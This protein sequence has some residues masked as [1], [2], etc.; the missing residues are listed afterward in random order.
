[1]K[2]SN[3]KL[4][5]QKI[6]DF[7]LTRA[8]PFLIII[9]F[10]CNTLISQNLQ[11]SFGNQKEVNIIREENIS[12]NG[13]LGMALE[14]SEDGR[15]KMLPEWNNGELFKIFNTE[16]RLKNKST[17]WYGEHAGKWLY[18]TAKAVARTGDPVLKELLL[19]EANYL[20]DN[21]EADGYMGTYSPEQR[22]TN[23]E[24]THN[25]SWDIWNL[26][27]ML[28][29]L[30]EVNKHF[31]DPKYENAA[32]KIGELFL[33]VFGDGQNNITD[34]GTR[35][36]ISASIILDP[37]IELYNLT[38]DGRYLNF[39]KLIIKEVE[40]KEGLQIISA[41][42]Q[43]KDMVYIGEGK[44]Y[45]LIWNLTALAKFYKI[46]GE[47]KYIEAV[48]NAWNN[49]VN[50][51]LSICGGPWG[52]IG[53][54]YEL[55]NRA[56]FWNPYGYIETCSSMAW[57]Q[58]N[59]EL[60]ELSGQAKYIK[61]IEKTTFNALIGAQYPNGIDWCYH[62]FTNGERHIAHFNDCCPSSGALGLEELPQIIYSYRQ[63]GISCNIYCESEADLV[64]NG[65]SKVQI[66]QKTDYPFDGHVS[67]SVMP[68]K[69][70][71]FP[72]FI[73]IPDWSDSVKISV[74]GKNIE[75][76]N[77]VAGEYLKLDREWMRNDEIEI[78]FPLKLN[79]VRKLEKSD[80]PQGGEDIYKVEW[81]AL[82]RGPIVYAASGLFNGENREKVYA[83]PKRNPANYF[84]PVKTPE[85]FHGP[86]YSLKI[87][88]KDQVLFL[89][90]FE[91]GGR[92]EFS[93]RLTWIQ[94]SIR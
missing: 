77:S 29:G 66:K 35:Q 55:F 83:L 26:S 12:V 74:N 5:Q 8:T 31:P 20:I 67:I 58:L 78:V 3:K 22:L 76:N 28:I 13:F 69:K 27:Y 90:Y 61:E 65:S 1:M 48:N 92:N 33:T 80:K 59:R 39:A 57:I 68:D 16:Y 53:K 34:Y 14:R 6:S 93:W 25:R 63:S 11:N 15:L 45:Q 86:A 38:N 85:Y 84:F 56:H 54:M 64:L 41:A 40:G 42:L 17:N 88:G 43:H 2:Y 30:I 7:F 60:F 72:I 10:N 37:V 62:S 23:P 46:T 36:G 94:D 87:P 9:L 70:M 51:H 44:A 89:P 82:T 19:K 52:G 47:E 75:N 32:L 81:F 21:Q 71:A 91:S 4:I 24:V 18:S 79:I 73:R 49:I 50:F